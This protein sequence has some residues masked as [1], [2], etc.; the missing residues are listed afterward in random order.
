LRPVHRHNEGARELPIG[1]RSSAIAVALRQIQ[2]Y[3]QQAKAAVSS[4]V[5]ALEAWKSYSRRLPL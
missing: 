3:R 2:H 1:W 4:T 5:E